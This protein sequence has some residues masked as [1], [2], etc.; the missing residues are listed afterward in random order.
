MADS[1]TSAIRNDIPVPHRAK[2]YA[3]LYVLEPG[4]CTDVQVVGSL[5][6]G[7][8]RASINYIQHKHGR[9][10]TTRTVFKDP[11]DPSARTIRVWR[12]A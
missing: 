1:M 6:L 2:R 12:T 8:L 5:A 9:R 10:L 3:A 11:G 7:S 4:Q